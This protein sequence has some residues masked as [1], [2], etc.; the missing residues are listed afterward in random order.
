MLSK[1]RSK[2]PKPGNPAF[3]QTPASIW[4]LRTFPERN[5][6]S[7]GA[8]N[9]PEA[10]GLHATRKSSRADSQRQARFAPLGRWLDRLRG[11]RDGTPKARLVLRLAHET[12]RA[13]AVGLLDAGA[14]LAGR[15]FTRLAHARTSVWPRRRHLALVGRRASTQKQCAEHHRTEPCQLQ[16]QPPPPP[17]MPPVAPSDTARTCSSMPKATSSTLMV[18]C[19]KIRRSHG[20]TPEHA[21]RAAATSARPKTRAHPI[22]PDSIGRT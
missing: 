2:A 16:P 7:P 1:E 22:D 11:Q 19:A 20:R 10:D 18:G 5:F 12:G 14:E 13:R 6:R 3:I 9:R 4:M 15:H 17:L 21:D 8:G